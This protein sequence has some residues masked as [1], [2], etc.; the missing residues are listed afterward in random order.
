MDK[1]FLD[2]VKFL[3]SRNN[4]ISST[5]ISSKLGISTKTI[6][7]KIKL[8]NN[9]LRGKG[10]IIHKKPR[11]GI[12]LD[13]IDKDRWV[14]YSYQE[15]VSIFEQPEQRVNFIILSLLT[16]DIPISQEDLAEKLFV[17]FSTVGNDLTQ[18]RQEL[19]KNNLELINIRKEGYVID[20]KEF[21]L[22]K[23]FS[24]RINTTDWL[25]LLKS[26]LNNISFP[27][28]KKIL[29]RTLVN[30]EFHLSENSFEN[31]CIH[32]FIMITRLEYVNYNAIPFEVE[33]LQNF[34]QK[35]LEISE[36][37]I[38]RIEELTKFRVP[39]VEQYLI[40]IQL[41]TKQVITQE[42]K[43]LVT[44]K[45]LS[46]VNKMIEL[47]KISFHINLVEDNELRMNLALHLIPLKYRLQYN[48]DVNNP[49]VEEIKHNFP[50]GFIV[51]TEA[52]KVIENEMMKII[53]DEEVAL[54]ALHFNLAIQRNKDSQPIFKKK[55][56]VIACST[57]TGSAK[58]LEFQIIEKF[59]NYLNKIYVTD[60]INLGKTDLTNYDFI[61]STIPIKTKFQIP[62]IHINYFLT[63]ADSRKLEKIF[64]LYDMEKQIAYFFSKDLFIKN[65]KA[66]TKSEVIEQLVQIGNQRISMPDG[67]KN[68]ILKREKLFTTEIGNLA[69]IPHPLELFDTQTYAIVGILEK[70][71]IWATKP[72]QLVML[73][74]VGKYDKENLQIFY[75]IISKYLVDDKKIKALIENPNFDYFLNQIRDIS[76]EDGDF[77]E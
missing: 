27:Q 63:D 25:D 65:I 37:I 31:L 60:T 50:L 29:K 36:A 5:E 62:L 46:L 72:V 39:M 24:E 47:V 34:N 4:P 15:N 70:P 68:S 57:G 11:K 61:L 21:N 42:D 32:I 7:N 33:D 51:A 12:W 8:Y 43:V 28:I 56:I 18:V 30:N 14:N 76:R 22:R 1:T 67:I 9:E 10:A 55:N 19:L 52:V 40:M 49:L 69:A 38:I 75:Q 54:L 45:I 73:L 53:G 77:Y 3:E 13:I 66:D 44:P 59:S 58:M 35:I 71:I 6:F 64:S 20:G 41:S 74:I 23:F 17:S 26:E 16:T 48:I 2:I